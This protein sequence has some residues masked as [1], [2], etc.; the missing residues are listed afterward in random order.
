MFFV[1]WFW[2]FFDFARGGGGGGGGGGGVFPTPLNIT[3]RRRVRPPAFS[4]RRVQIAAFIPEGNGSA[5]DPFPLPLLNTLILLCSGTTVTWAH[6]SLIHGDRVG[7]KAGPVGDDRSGRIVTDCI[8]AYEYAVAPFGFGGNNLFLGLLHGDRISRASTFWS[9]R[10]FLAVCLY[11]RL[12][13]GHFHSAPALRL[14]SGGVV[15]AL[16]RCG[17]AVP[18]RRR[19]CLGRLGRPNSIDDCGR[20]SG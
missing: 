11:P 5:Y 20:K 4:A 18:V 15:L 6:H 16:R 1:G 14:R 10:I 8:Q 9:A 13:S 7:L 17:V 2:S 3:M 19:L 12:F